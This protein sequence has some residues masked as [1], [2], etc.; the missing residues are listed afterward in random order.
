MESL[1]KPDNFWCLWAVILG[2]VALS[3]W[4]EQRFSWAA[5]MSGPVVAMCIALA[6][7]NVGIMPTVT[8]T[9][10]LD[11]QGEPLK[12]AAGAV[13]KN[14][15][16]YEFILDEL[17]PLAL[18]LLLFRANILQ[19]L[20]TTGSMFLAFHVASLGTVLGAFLAAFAMH[21]QLTDVWQ[22]VGIMT[23][24]YTG[25]AVNFFAV[26]SSYDTSANVKGSLI[27]ADAFIMTLLF[28]ILLLISGARWAK[29]LYPHPH[30]S[31][32]V[33]SRK[34]AA[35]HWK[36]KG[37]S[38][39]D[40]AAALAIAVSIVALA[41]W[42][43]VLAV[44]GFAVPESM[45]AKLAGNL[46]VHI[47]LWSVAAATLF[48]RVL[49]KINGSEEL[50]SF[51]LYIFLF[52]IGLPS[53]LVTV[54]RE[55]PMMF[56]LCL[57]MA[58]TNLAFTLVVGKLLRLNLEDLLISVNATLGGPPSAVAMAVSRGWSNLVLPALLVGIWG[59]IIGTPLGLIVGA[60]ARDWLS[61]GG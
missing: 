2:G 34:L 25:G 3:I 43:S 24:S 5:K 57:I 30:T 23:G 14:P 1:I 61:G 49:L 11:A 56:A 20:R 16:V 50:G 17:V 19:I 40:I 8:E 47:T 52:V 51:L 9:E 31:D 42:T 7:S 44:Q 12:N 58:I 37:I 33:D 36:R 32:E 41:K 46:F 28:M 39:F 29:R 45:A 4:L 54:L 18:P 22:M 38:L 27:V 59:Y 48:H 53:N 60:T 35:E 15:G 55:A 26:A 6:L 13:I 10:V 21:N